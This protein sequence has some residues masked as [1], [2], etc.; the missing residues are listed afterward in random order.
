MP[1][2]KFEFSP[3]AHRQHKFKLRHPCCLHS[4][5]STE[6]PSSSTTIT[7]SYHL[8]WSGMCSTN[9]KFLKFCGC[10]NNV[11]SCRNFPSTDQRPVNEFEIALR[12]ESARRGFIISTSNPL[13]RVRYDICYDERE[14]LLVDICGQVKHSC[15]AGRMLS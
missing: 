2:N 3:R 9:L 4:T 15:S 7:G 13:S 8:T 6:F 5:N 12:N 10:P 1:V 11:C 14:G